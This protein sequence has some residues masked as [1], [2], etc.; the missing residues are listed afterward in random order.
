MSIGPPLFFSPA[1]D[2]FELKPRQTGVFTLGADLLPVSI[3]TSMIRLLPQLT[4][5]TG[6]YRGAKHY[7]AYALPLY[8]SSITWPLPLKRPS[9]VPYDLDKIP[10]EPHRERAEGTSVSA[11]APYTQAAR[12]HR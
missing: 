4:C 11:S 6:A 8:M 10:C 3:Q 9:T 1:V 5:A 12:R 7:L 2:W